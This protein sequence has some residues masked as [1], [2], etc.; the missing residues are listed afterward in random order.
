[1]PERTGRNIR[2]ITGYV[3]NL[4]AYPRWM[5]EREVDFT[6]CRLSGDYDS[7]EV[8]CTSCGFGEAC[9]WLNLNRTPPS[10]N[11]PLPELLQALAAA[12]EY[13]Q[14]PTREQPVHE[15]D[16]RC[17]ACQWIREARGFLRVQRHK[18]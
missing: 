8:Q 9:R 12:V 5:I 18:T 15:H 4:L 10:A 2:T 7:N 11:A 14:S 13:L 6:N 16:C 3:A 1:M 17:D